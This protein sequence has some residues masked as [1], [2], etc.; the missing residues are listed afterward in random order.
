MVD[1]STC[2][3]LSTLL[4]IVIAGL[5]CAC[6]SAPANASTHT[7]TVHDANRRHS[8]STTKDRSNDRSATRDAPPDTDSSS[9]TPPAHE[10][11]SRDRTVESGPLGEPLPMTGDALDEQTADE[12]RDEQTD[13]G[14]KPDDDS[15]ATGDSQPNSSEG[16]ED[17]D[18]GERDDADELDRDNW[19]QPSRGSGGDDPPDFIDPSEPELV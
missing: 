2:R 12:R 8:E 18:D 15:S 10:A 11:P 6:D 4:V 5:L 9:K 16:N 7:P 14:D 13:G 3:N 17:S 1:R 19:F